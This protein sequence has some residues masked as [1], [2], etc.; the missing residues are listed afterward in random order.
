V[1]NLVHTL[2]PRVIEHVRTPSG[3]LVIV[4]FEP[5]DV[6]LQLS[7]TQYLFFFQS[8]ALSAT[9][10]FEGRLGLCGACW[11]F[12]FDQFLLTEIK[13]LTHLTHQF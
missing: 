9:C 3:M 5:W 7:T 11:W 12:Q 2:S 8:S 13:H 6:M 4:L 10:D 1:I